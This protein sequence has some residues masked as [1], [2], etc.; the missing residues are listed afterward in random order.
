MNRVVAAIETGRCA[1][2]VSGSLLNDAD[3][4]LALRERAHGVSAITLS[5]PQMGPITAPS[6]AALARTTNQPGG[7][8][9]IVNPQATDNA[10]LQ[11]LANSLAK[12][13]HKPTVLVAAQTFNPF[14]FGT[15]FKGL[16]VGHIKARGKELFKGLPVPPAIAAPVV[17]GEKPARKP[18]D[19]P[20]A[21]RFTFVGRD[22][23]LA[24]IREML[25][26]GGPIVVSGPAGIGKT[27][28]VEHALAGQSLQRLPDLVLGWGT[29]ADA[30]FGRLAEICKAGG[31]PQLFDALAAGG[32]APL[33][34]VQIA[35]AA[36]QAATETDGKVMV[37]HDLHHA[38]GRDDGFFRR[39]RLELLLMALLTNTYPLRIVFL[40][41]SQPVFH[42]ER[43]GTTLRRLALTGVKGRFLFDIFEAYKA[44]EFP[45]EKFGPLSDKIHGH[46]MVARAYAIEVRDRENGIGLLDDPKFLRM[47]D[48]HDVASYRKLLERK[49]EK[50]NEDERKALALVA[51]FRLP[52]T[53][54][55]MAELGIGR[56][57]R[58][59]L[60]AD[61]LLET[62]GTEND[63]R[64][65]VHSLVRSTLSLR[66][67]SDFDVL[68]RVAELYNAQARAGTDPVVRMALAQE[69]NRNA[70]T[71]RASRLCLKLPVPDD[72][73]VLESVTGMIRSKSPH[74]ELAH[75]RLAEV[76]KANPTNADA[77]LLLLELY[78]RAD[79]DKE[80]VQAAIDE[81][82]ATAPVPEVFQQVVSFLMFKK[83]KGKATAVLEQGIA[84]LPDESRLRTRLAAL[85]MR[86]GRRKEAIEH[87]KEAM[88]LD[89]MLPDAYGLLGTARRDEGVEALDDAENLL[90]EAVR[91]APEDATQI[92]RL[93]DLLIA[94]A[95]LP[96]DRQ[97][98]MRE[99]AKMLLDRV[100][101]GDRRTA[102]AHLLLAQLIREEGGDLERAAW[103]VKKAK[104]LTERHSERNHRIALEFALLAL[105][106]GELDDAERELRDIA[107]KDP[108]NDRVFAG[109]ARLLEARQLYIPAHAELLRARERTP[110]ASIERAW[111]DAELS[112]LQAIIE[113]QVAGMVA[114]EAQPMQVDEAPASAGGHQ[115][116]IRR[117]RGGDD[118]TDAP[119][120]GGEADPAVEAAPT[121]E[122]TPE[123]DVGGRHLYDDA[124]PDA[125]PEGAAE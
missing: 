31:S 45:R 27:Q 95:R 42:R 8:V 85:L 16:A 81:A 49:V 4:V 116:V 54:G 115:R 57:A 28:L 48:A 24:Q 119:S 56:K 78:E 94:R 123:G 77:H 89:P 121:E 66:E 73:A 23:E 6:D 62:V 18:S 13:A 44:P 98:A 15:L 69:C 39:S 41:R 52:V 101:R 103:L 7:V 43:A 125:E 34:L 47:E 17:E 104:K 5:G 93:V 38:M 37:I 22:D 92:S 59:Q 83:A 124:E 53:G 9:V 55:M 10:G 99:E 33:Q 14:Q 71:G 46:P 64:F 87:L 60:L 105:H 35:I 108:S 68:A 29:A 51:H 82:I 75:Q 20:D 3:V 50:L 110:Q 118:T 120:E 86:Q 2:A 72:D 19:G 102:D 30:L 96:G 12:G 100:L 11:L 79:A 70:I 58:L 111:Y 25:A 74:F 91:L 97:A 36:L 26:T 80:R 106:R 114:G 109:L 32:V 67:T 84:L 117:R 61:G 113:A 63:K 112:R 76:L 107:T 65:V 21:P 40:S 1:F 90:R 88:T 122:P